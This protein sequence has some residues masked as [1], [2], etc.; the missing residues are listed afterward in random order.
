MNLVFLQAFDPP[1]FI[2][3]IGLLTLATNVITEV[4]KKTIAKIPAQITA[5]IVAMVLRVGAF[6]AYA[7]ITEI[8]VM[9][10][11]V[12]GAVVMGF[13]VSYAAQFGFD[14]LKELIGKYRKGV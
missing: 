3:V 4:L 9:W 1:A 14:K 10:Y 13:F 2:F 12:A 6:F 7:E 5:L 8:A 11:M